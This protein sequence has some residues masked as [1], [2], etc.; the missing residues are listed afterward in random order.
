MELR[1]LEHFLAVAEE[2][3]FTRASERI[4]LVQS[5]LSVS[6]KALENELG[7]SLFDRTTHR[8]E[9]T[10]A[11]RALVPAARAT[12]AA[13]QAAR[14]AV[15][16]VVGGVRGTLNLGIMQSLSAMDLAGLLT[17]FHSE[18]PG[19]ELRPRPARGGS[20][21]LA[22][23]VE[24]GELDLAFLSVVVRSHLH[25]SLI[26]IASEPVLVA[27]PPGHRLESRESL[28]IAE[29][30]GETFVEV[31]EGWGTRLITD[32]AFAE[33]GAQRA[34]SVELADLTTLTELVR[35]GLGL[36]LLPASSVANAHP[37]RLIPL[38]PPL[39]WDIALAVPTNRP[40][41][42]AARAFVDLVRA[43]WPGPD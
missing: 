38:R 8:V 27:L 35:A 40:L 34:I 7:C 30:D 42:A 19:V 29:L 13:A 18:R 39:T 32:L 6:I 3:S 21:E 41:S 4:H 22:R 2:G 1:R 14:D 43:T 9:L 24:S 31:P 12:L 28:T 37:V 23:Q 5:A 33:A 11:G 10:D 36:A 20:A 17:R 26:P 15:D 25:L 16:A